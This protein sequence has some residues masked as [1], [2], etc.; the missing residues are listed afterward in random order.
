MSDYIPE[1]ILMNILNR[2]SVKSLGKCRCVSS[3]WNNL[4]KSSLFISSHLTRQSPGYLLTYCTSEPNRKEHYTLHFDQN[5]DPPHRPGNCLEFDIPFKSHNP[6][7]R[8]LG[9]VN[10]LVCIVDDSRVQTYTVILWNPSVRKHVLLPP[11]NV[12]YESHGGFDCLMGFGFDSARNDY[13]VVRIVY[14]IEDVREDLSIPPKIEVFSLSEGAW[15]CI[16]GPGALAHYKFQPDRRGQ[17]LVNG[18]PHWLTFKNLKNETVSHFILLFG[19]KDEVFRKMVLPNCL[20]GVDPPYLIISMV[21]ESLAV[22]HNDAENLCCETWVRKDYEMKS[23]WTKLFSVSLLSL[24]LGSWKKGHIL[25]QG[26]TG[27]M[28]SLDYERCRYLKTGINAET[29][30]S[31]LWTHVESLV[32]LDRSDNANPDEALNPDTNT[33]QV[34][35]FHF[36]ISASYL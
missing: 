11:P 31:S 26:V 6:F 30:H 34:A 19:M 29:G 20:V 25:L 36:N 1:E 10:G 22:N 28:I 23:S 14:P 18:N 9:S 17:A 3:S 32:L 5:P 24:A 7:F 27:N 35:L 16:E 21:G 15:K 4:I 8:V 13:K 12:T 2:L 33:R